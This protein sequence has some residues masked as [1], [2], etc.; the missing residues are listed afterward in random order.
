MLYSLHIINLIIL[1]KIPN[2]QCNYV[3]Y[4][5]YIY[6]YNINC[7]CCAFITQRSLPRQLHVF[8]PNQLHVLHSSRILSHARCGDDCERDISRNES[9]L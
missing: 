3:L 7:C 8:V 4:Y 9:R 2:H 5:F 6:Y 1:F